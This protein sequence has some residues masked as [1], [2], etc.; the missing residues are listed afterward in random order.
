M[1]VDS[2][3]C[4]LSRLLGSLVGNDQDAWLFAREAYGRIRPLS[5]GEWELT[6]AL[7]E[8][9]LILAGLNWLDWICVQGRIF[10]DYAA[11]YVRLDEMLVRLAQ[12]HSSGP[13]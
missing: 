13:T 10:E 2:P 11:I 4:D 1:Q 8:A 5:L 3:A 12:P 9:I 7:D 6:Q